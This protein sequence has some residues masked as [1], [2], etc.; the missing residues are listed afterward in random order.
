MASYRYR[1]EI[2]AKELGASINNPRADVHIYAKPVSVDMGHAFKAKSEGKTVI[3]DYCDLHFEE[4]YYRELIEYADLVTCSTKWSAEYLREDFGVE[5]LVIPDPYEFEEKPTHCNGDKLLWFGHPNN[6]DSLERI[7][8]QI[9]GFPLTVVSNVVGAVQWSLPT[10][11]DA[12]S[13][14]DI[15]ILP[16]TAPYKSPNRALEAIR[17]GCFVVAEPHPSLEDFPIYI[18]NIRKGIEWASKNPGQANEMTTKAQDFIRERWSPK[19]LA[20]AWR[21]AIQKAQSNCTLAR[22]KSTGTAG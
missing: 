10:L 15:V 8:N 21:T 7:K 14:S 13:T 5:A 9:E 11:K 2:P 12:L 3:V 19:T 6:Y 4:K 17:S 22:E 16:E 20:N 1:A 18:G